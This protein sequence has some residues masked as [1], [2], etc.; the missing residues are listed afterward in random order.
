MG[1][2]PINAVDPF[3]LMIPPVMEIVNFLAIYGEKLWELANYIPD[4]KEYAK[5]RRRR[6]R[7]K[8]YDEISIQGR[9]QREAV[10]VIYEGCLDSC[11]LKKSKDECFD[12]KSC[13]HDCW[14]DYLMNLQIYVYGYED[15]LRSHAFWNTQ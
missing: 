10:N 11:V 4:A 3:G 1:N 14:K 7:Q 15:W 12:F 9:G 6:E 13:R 8:I 5:E 2:N